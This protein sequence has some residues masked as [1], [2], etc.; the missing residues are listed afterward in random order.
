MLK[1]LWPSGN[2]DKRVQIYQ[3]NIFLVLLIYSNH[4]I[5][6]CSPSF[7]VNSIHND[8]YLLGG[9]KA[10]SHCKTLGSGKGS[11]RIHTHKYTHTQFSHQLESWH[12]LNNSVQ[13]IKVFYS[14]IKNLQSIHKEHPGGC[15]CGEGRE[16][17]D[18]GSGASRCKLLY[19]EWI[20][21]KVL[22]FSRELYL[23]SRDKPSWKRIW[24]SLCDPQFSPEINLQHSTDHWG[25]C[26]CL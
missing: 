18:W 14:S 8:N 3:A 6:H 7:P 12:F 1:K 17:M 22:L 19:R 13:M 20:N 16:G 9:K 5:K 4:K 11:M 10:V 25:F 15:P 23:I 26:H 2:S 24:K 21:N